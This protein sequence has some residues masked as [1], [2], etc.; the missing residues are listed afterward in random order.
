M[1]VRK[2]LERL[3]VPALRDEPTRALGSKQDEEELE[4]G[5]D[6]LHQGGDAPRPAA[7]G[8]VLRPICGPRRAAVLVSTA[9]LCRKSGAYMMLPEYHSELYS[10]VSWAR[11]RGYAISVTNSGAEFA[12]ARA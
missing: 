7:P 6:A 11:Y 8:Y 2:G 3:V 5:G 12:E 4:G 10:D 9:R 1:V